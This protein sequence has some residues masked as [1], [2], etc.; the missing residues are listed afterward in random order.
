LFRDSRTAPAA[1]L[2]RVLRL[3]CCDGRIQYIDRHRCARTMAHR[4]LVG[5]DIW[6]PIPAGYKALTAA[7]L[8]PRLREEFA[9]RYDK[10]EHCLGATDVSSL[11]LAAA[12]RRPCSTTPRGKTATGLLRAHVQSIL[13]GSA[14]ARALAG[15]I[16]YATAR[17]R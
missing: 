17:V 1:R 15:L 3:Y 14:G 16:I 7:L 6:L 5:A 2:D 8:P 10:A 13:D 12:L 11:A 9:L 4:L